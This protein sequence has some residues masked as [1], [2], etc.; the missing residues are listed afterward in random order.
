M[1]V[2]RPTGGGRG[3]MIDLSLVL[4]SQSGIWVD[5]TNNVQVGGAISGP[6]PQPF[7]SPSPGTSAMMLLP[8]GDSPPVDT[9][10]VSR[11]GRELVDPSASKA[12]C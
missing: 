9:K 12:H 2:V 10:P 11:W 1:A 8:V 5:N 4:D 6:P 7:P 3:W